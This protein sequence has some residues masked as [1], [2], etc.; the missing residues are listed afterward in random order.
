[1]GIA[2]RRK[3]TI[4]DRTA[5]ITADNF[6]EDTYLAPRFGLIEFFRRVR[7]DQLSILTPDLFGRSLV[8]SR[9]LFLQS[10]LVN[11]P[12]YIEHVLLTNHANYGKSHFVR[13]MLGPLLGEGLLISEGEL[14]RRQRRI[15]A[16]AFHNRR[17]ADFIATMDKEIV[18][19]F[20][21]VLLVCDDLGLIGNEMFAVDGCKLP[22]NASKEWSGTRADF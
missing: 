10:F 2:L 7:T 14:W 4:M 18:E 9:I 17:I 19:L 5:A 3:E 22:S 11:K 15:A 6:V 8:R 12:E 16:P 1:M 20:R 13:H 21:N